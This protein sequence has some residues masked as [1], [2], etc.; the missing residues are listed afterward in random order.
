MYAPTLDKIVRHEL[1]LYEIEPDGLRRTAIIK[2]TKY[3]VFNHESQ[4]VPRVPLSDNAE[5]LGNCVV[6]T[7]LGFVC[8]EDYLAW[9]HCI[10]C[11]RC[12]FAGSDAL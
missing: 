11:E 9:S 5:P 6:A 1:L 7:L 12:A 4:I 8:V 10:T 2:V 3:S